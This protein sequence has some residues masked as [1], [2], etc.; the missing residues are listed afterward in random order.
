M[1]QQALDRFRQINRDSHPQVV[2]ATYN[3][4]ST[5]SDAGRLNEARAHLQTA[6]ELASEVF[7]EGHLNTAV[8]QAK[9]GE[10]LA[11]LSRFKRAEA[12]LIPARDRINAQL[13]DDH[14]RSRQ[15]DEMVEELNSGWG[16]TPPPGSA[17]TR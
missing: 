14:W 7:P 12:L 13:G 17:S 16:R 1:L 15:A 9:Y 5:L 10:C 4:G 11:R 6:F 3:L 8:M 2:V